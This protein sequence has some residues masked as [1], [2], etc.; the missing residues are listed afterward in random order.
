MNIAIIKSL[1]DQY[2]VSQLQSA[3][4]ALLN[5]APLPISVE[6]KDEGEQ[7]THI[8]AAIFC[9]QEMEKTGMNINLA[10]RAFS[11]RVRDS[12]N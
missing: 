10:V 4:E 5:E 7:L 3:E 1:V 12:I 6:G 8:L 11:Q 9:K 2:S